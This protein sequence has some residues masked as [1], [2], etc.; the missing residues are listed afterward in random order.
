MLCDLI[1]ILLIKFIFSSAIL[2][3]SGTRVICCREGRAQWQATCHL[4]K[5]QVLTKYA[6]WFHQATNNTDFKL[7]PWLFY[8]GCR[9]VKWQA[10][11][12][13]TAGMLQSFLQSAERK[14][15][16]SSVF[17]TAFTLVCGQENCCWPWSS[18]P[19]IFLT[20]SKFIVLHVVH[21]NYK[22]VT[23]TFFLPFMYPFTELEHVTVS[24]KKS[25]LDAD[26]QKHQKDAAILQLWNWAQSIACLQLWAC[27]CI[28]R[29]FQFT[30]VHGTVRKWCT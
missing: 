5:V 6:S 22:L 21:R 12:A 30:R 29:I 18:T 1:D 7:I 19:I 3:P 4:Y 15:R 9:A 25:H 26:A 23:L 14:S 11:L 27:G 24:R 17:Y 13:E 8:R 10:E 28:C 16:C 2:F 20:S